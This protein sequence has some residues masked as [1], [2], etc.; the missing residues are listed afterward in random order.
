LIRRPDEDHAALT[1]K[2]LSCGSKSDYRR[3]G[4]TLSGADDGTVIF[5]A[6]VREW[7]DVLVR[8]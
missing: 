6:V 7:S 1:I 2:E 5:L 8:R 4:L 3:A